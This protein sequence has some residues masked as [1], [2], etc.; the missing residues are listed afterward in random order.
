MAA[1]VLKP[2]G[3]PLP[4]FQRLIL[5]WFG[6]RML[7]RK[8]TWE[9]AP[10]SIEATARRML[11][12]VAGLDAAALRRPVLVPPMRGLED[13]SRYWSP[14]MVFQHLAIT[15]EI[16]TAIILKLS[17]REP[18]T[19][20][21]GTADV[22]PA[23]DAGAVDVE[24]FRVLHSDLGKR[25]GADV[26]TNR[27]GATFRHPW[28]GPLTAADWYALFAAHLLIHEKQMELILAA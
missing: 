14:A 5:R 9:S 22:K 25:I 1:P 7:R 11:D 24:K 20:K 26:G 28:F 12:A 23:T 10:P 4:L 2:P 6:R 16:F 15:G 13:S 19:D 18:I 17:H 21:R 27:T 8:F 3:A